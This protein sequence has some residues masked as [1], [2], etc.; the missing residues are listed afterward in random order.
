MAKRLR[1]KP[2]DIIPN[3][4]EVDTNHCGLPWPVNLQ[5]DEF[6]GVVKIKNAEIWCDAE[7]GEPITSLSYYKNNATLRQLYG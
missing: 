7:T 6:I 4:G 2:G 3:I 5:G 1:Y